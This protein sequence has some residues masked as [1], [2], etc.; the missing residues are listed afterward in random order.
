MGAVNSRCLQDRKVSTRYPIILQVR[1]KVGCLRKYGALLE[2]VS[3]ILGIWKE[4]LV[5]TTPA[6]NIGAAS[7]ELK[8]SGIGVT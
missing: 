5:R 2:C 1:K 4:N 7:S 8:A 3:E 6:H